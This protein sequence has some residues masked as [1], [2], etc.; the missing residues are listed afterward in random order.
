MRMGTGLREVQQGRRRGSA[1][2]KAHLRGI[3]SSVRRHRT[4]QVQHHGI[5][6]SHLC[7]LDFIA[8]RESVLGV[9]CDASAMIKVKLDSLLADLPVMRLRPSEG[10]QV[11]HHD[12]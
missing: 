7:R 4:L 1:F 3:A 12:R 10:Q 2:P 6:A 5:A 8:T 9:G 11:I